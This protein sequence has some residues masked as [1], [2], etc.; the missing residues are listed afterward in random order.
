MSLDE[1]KFLM[2][3][4]EQLV[5]INLPQQRIDRFTKIIKTLYATGN[6]LC[7]ITTDLE[8]ALSFHP[9]KEI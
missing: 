6:H 3:L 7:T 9:K 5:G 8:P 2:F 1:R 4:S